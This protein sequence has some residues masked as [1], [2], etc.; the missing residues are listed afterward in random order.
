MALPMPRQSRVGCDGFAN[1]SSAAPDV[2]GCGRN[3]EGGPNYGATTRKR[4]LHQV[5]P[6]GK[7]ASIEST[8]APDCTANPRRRPEEDH[9]RQTAGLDPD[10]GGARL[11]WCESGSHSSLAEISRTGPRAGASPTGHGRLVAHAG[12][13]KPARGTTS[14]SR[15]LYQTGS[16]REWASH[17]SAS[18]ADRSADSW[19]SLYLHGQT[20]ARVH[21]DLHGTRVQG[22]AYC[23]DPAVPR[24]GSRGTPGAFVLVAGN[25]R[26]AGIAGRCAYGVGTDWVPGDA[27]LPEPDC[28]RSLTPGDGQ[29]VRSTRRPPS[30]TSL[31]PGSDNNLAASG[32]AASQSGGPSPRPPR[33]EPRGIWKTRCR[34]GIA[35]HGGNEQCDDIDANP[36]SNGT[37]SSSCSGPGPSWCYSRFCNTIPRG[38]FGGPFL[39]LPISGV[40][41]GEYHT[42]APCAIEPTASNYRRQ[43]SVQS[44]GSCFHLS[45]RVGKPPR[46]GRAYP[47]VTS[48]V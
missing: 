8:I 10:V 16:C 27:V 37:W 12:G 39:S 38:H 46:L 48:L 7:R 17:A 30:R 19:T 2:Y 31:L 15:M 1:G 22:Q 43:S 6:R 14:S 24:S 36:S 26:V 3:I 20:D 40:A 29:P 44:S 25:C 11:L 23:P 34:I 21:W 5:D 47:G 41:F 32:P 13:T 33:Q 28:Q 9:W 35:S 42:H 18:P 4:M 45:P